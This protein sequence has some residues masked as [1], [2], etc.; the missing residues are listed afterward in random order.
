MPRQLYTEQLFT[1]QKIYINIQ[2]RNIL[3]K[4]FSFL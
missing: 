3:T 1:E 4:I 2:D